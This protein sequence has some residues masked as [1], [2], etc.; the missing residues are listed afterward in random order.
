METRLLDRQWIERLLSESA[1]GA[2][3][4]LADSA[5]Q[6]ALADVDSPE[7]IEIGLEKAVAELLTTIA[8][9]APDPELIDLFRI[10]WDYRNLK[11]LLKASLLKIEGGETGVVDGIGTVPAAALETAVRDKDYTMLPGFLANA[12][13]DAGEAYRDQGELSIIDQIID[14]SLWDHSL[15]TATAAGNGFLSSYF[16]AEIDLINIKTFVRIK[17]MN[18]DQ[19]DLA[20]ALIPGGTLDLSFFRA[21]LG[22]PIGTFAGSIEY[23]RY[24]VLAEVLRESSPEN[25]YALELA[26]DNVLIRFVERAKTAAYGIEPLVAFILY[27]TMEIKLVR[28]AIVA[29]LDGV[30]RGEVEERLRTIHV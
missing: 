5:Y 16:Q 9:M 8:E 12:A 24:G 3:K 19:N 1:D 25:R 27:R 26:C 6:D 11:S 15:A 18:R 29:K 2:L 7:A 20:R 22:E 10:R 4:A 28:T 23:G 30:E 17:A 14:A 21:A 13:R